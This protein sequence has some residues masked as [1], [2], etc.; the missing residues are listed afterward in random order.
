M[1]QRRHAVKTESHAERQPL[2]RFHY[3]LL[4]GDAGGDAIGQV[5]LD[6]VD[7]DCRDLVGVDQRLHVVDISAAPYLRAPKHLQRT[8]GGDVDPVAR[9][10]V[11]QQPGDDL[12]QVEEGRFRLQLGGRLAR[13]HHIS[14]PAAQQR[15]GD[16]DQKA[17]PVD[18]KLIHEIVRR[19]ACFDENVTRDPTAEEL[20]CREVV[21]R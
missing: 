19:A 6:L 10:G 20:A 8:N 2:S 18:A 17:R 11:R 15:H 9:C 3:P 1:R 12:I 4:G 14:S 16:L 5:R 13:G 21:I 7:L